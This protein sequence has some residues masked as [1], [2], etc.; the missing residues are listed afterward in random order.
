MLGS[1]QGPHAPSKGWMHMCSE[2]LRLVSGSLPD[3]LDL[4]FVATVMCWR[5]ERSCTRW[6]LAKKE[7]EKEKESVRLFAGRCD[8]RWVFA[9]GLCTY[10]GCDDWMCV[11]GFG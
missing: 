2:D 3:Y 1:S 5:A 6:L 8:F 10:Y 9:I 4:A 7:K 11:L